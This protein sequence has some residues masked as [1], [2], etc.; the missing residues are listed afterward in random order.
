MQNTLL[1]GYVGRVVYTACFSVKY[2]Y[3]CSNLS[4]FC[5]GLKRADI[6]TIQVSLDCNKLKFFMQHVGLQDRLEKEMKIRDGATRLLGACTHE[7]QLLE[8]GKTLHTSNA[9]TLV[10]MSQLQKLRA[11][12]VMEV[13]LDEPW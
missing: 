3:V 4:T 10:Y 1:F 13:S 2:C 7:T 11:A 9:R 5:W 12:E 6:D 8:A